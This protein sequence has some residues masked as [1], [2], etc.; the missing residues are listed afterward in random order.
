[1]HEIAVGGAPRVRL[2]LWGLDSCRVLS[3]S[4]ALR[5]KVR[6]GLDGLMAYVVHRLCTA[7]DANQFPGHA[8]GSK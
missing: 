5:R 7:S 2:A 8:V 4:A 3:G 1:M 6:A